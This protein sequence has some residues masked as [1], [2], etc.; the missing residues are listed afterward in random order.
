MFKK[1]L[2][3]SPHTDD[4]EIGCGATL[5]RLK[6]SGSEIFVVNF[7][8]AKNLTDVGDSYNEFKKSMS[9]LNVR[10]DMLGYKIRSIYLY[11]QE[12]L[13]YLYN[14]QI[15]ENFDVVFCHSTFDT[16]QDHEVITNEAIRAF[17]NTTILGYE[18]PWN[19]LKFSTDFFVEIDKSELD[20]K[21][22]LLNCYES[23]NDRPFMVKDYIYDIARTRGL[24]CGKK[25]AEAFQVIK[26]I[27]KK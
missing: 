24:Q 20:F 27:Y 8:L 23:Q 9:I 1:V 4:V 17:K 7:S 2:A 14:L 3:L 21:K 26:M 6:D 18:M 22:D 12:I 10:Y 11:R 19:N 16:H 15:K 13:D 25:Y 5:K